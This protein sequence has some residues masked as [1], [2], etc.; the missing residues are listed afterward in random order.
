MKMKRENLKS[1]E[2]LQS[3]KKKIV[4]AWNGRLKQHLPF[5]DGTKLSAIKK[6]QE[7]G[8]DLLSII[9]EVDA[10]NEKDLLKKIIS[11]LKR[12]RSSS[13]SISNFSLEA[14]CLEEA[15]L[16]VLS[17]DNAPDGQ[18]LQLYNEV[19]KDIFILTQIV[20][21]Q[22]ADVY[23]YAIENGERAFCYFNCDGEILYTND[24]MLSLMGVGELSKREKLADFF[25]ETDSDFI[26]DL[27]CGKL[28]K[29][30]I[31]RML[32]FK[33]SKGKRLPVGAEISPII[34][35]GKRVGGYASLI[36]ISKPME[37][38]QKVYDKSPLGIIKINK[39]FKFTYANPVACEM[40]GAKS[41]VGKSVRDLFPEEKDWQKVE[42][43]LLQKRF[44]NGLA[45][46]YEVEVSTLGDTPKRIPVRISGIPETD[47]KGEIIGSLAILHSL[48]LEEVA[49][50]V[51]FDEMIIST[52]SSDLQHVRSFSQTSDLGWKGVWWKIPPYVKKWVFDKHNF[53][54]DDI[55]KFIDKLGQRKLQGDPLVHSLLQK[56]LLSMVRC[57]VFREN[58]SQREI[59]TIKRLPLHKATLMS[60]YA[61][62]KNTLEFRLDLMNRILS[63][64]HELDQIGP[65]IVKSLVEHYG[66]Q[67]ASFFLA[68]EVD[69]T[70]S[71]K[72]Q[73]ALGDKKVFLLA[74]VPE[75]RDTRLRLQV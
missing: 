13:Y 19:R 16:Q 75:R 1:R 47:P 49:R 14:Y 42:K 35:Q 24:T 31:L 29:Q 65:V 30:G 59:D 40:L 52:F 15:V 44:K 50:L 57:P 53:Y 33:N 69:G 43:H 8:T 9:L 68:D 48:E 39:K 4:Q 10:K 34:V 26:Q 62:E 11:I 36:D 41:L 25:A 71:L 70:F 60:R 21:Q 17:E 12:I 6:E 61:E 46:E 7:K 18:L 51:P 64:C 28:G 45:D 5:K 20:L 58:N 3:K 66:W 22:S 73:K 54:V 63:V 56:N 38:Q 27:I 2:F 74:P 72:G 32:V 23:E 37:S 55:A 67:N